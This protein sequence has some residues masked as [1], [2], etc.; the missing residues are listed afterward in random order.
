[1]REER[2]REFQL[3]KL[4]AEKEMKKLQSWKRKKNERDQAIRLK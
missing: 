4:Q 2:A 1:M 3:K